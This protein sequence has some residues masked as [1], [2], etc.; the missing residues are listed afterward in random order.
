MQIDNLI[1]TH[2]TKILLGKKLDPGL[3][4]WVFGKKGGTLMSSRKS[5]SQILHVADYALAK[6]LTVS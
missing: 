2:I 4:K 6:V 3:V 5:P 1:L